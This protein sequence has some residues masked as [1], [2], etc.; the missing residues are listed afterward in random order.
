[1]PSGL[2]PG[3]SPRPLSRGSSR[4]LGLFG[5]GGVSRPGPS[6]PGA[7]LDAPGLA[8]LRLLSGRLGRCGRVPPLMTTSM[9]SPDS[10]SLRQQG[11]SQ[12]LELVDVAL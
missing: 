6:R 2:Q 11:L 4:G 8:S 5:V 12:P 7:G 9:S 3:G 1:M 10:V